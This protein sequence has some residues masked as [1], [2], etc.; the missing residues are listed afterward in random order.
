MAGFIWA[1][2]GRALARTRRIPFAGIT[3]PGG[4]R[5]HPVVVAQAVATLAEMSPTGCHGIA[6]G[7]GEALNEVPLGASWEAKSERQERLRS[8]YDVVR[9]LLAGETV[10]KSGPINAT[11]AK[12]WV[13]PAR[14]PRL[15][16]AAITAETATWMAGWVDGLL[17]VGVDPTEIG[18]VIDA[19]RL[20]GGAAKPV[21]L[22]VDLCIGSSNAVALRAHREWRTSA[23]PP[24]ALADLGRRA[25]F[26]EVTRNVSREAVSRKV[27]VSASPSAIRGAPSRPH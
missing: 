4:A 18:K 24:A 9:R 11:E 15:F 8:A 21:H 3:I 1:W 23:L 12:V 17:T 13:L 5:F 7:S 27:I 16:G 10:T 25:E 20:A 2:H 6:F 22:K 14:P 19:F 26:E